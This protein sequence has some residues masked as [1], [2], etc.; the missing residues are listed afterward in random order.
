MMQWHGV[1]LESAKRSYLHLCCRQ[2]G[3]ASK[4]TILDACEYNVQSPAYS[5]QIKKDTDEKDT[6]HPRRNC[7]TRWRLKSLT[8][9]ISRQA[10]ASM[11]RLVITEL[12]LAQPLALRLSPEACLM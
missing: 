7:A 12:F 1:K 4:L 9:G 3:S 10:P 11:T 8:L 2:F 5:L 6:L